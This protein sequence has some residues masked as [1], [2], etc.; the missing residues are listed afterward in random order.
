MKCQRSSWVKINTRFNH[1]NFRL[2]I[3]G[4]AKNTDLGV[5]EDF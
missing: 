2:E 5:D 4:Y 3:G 1:K